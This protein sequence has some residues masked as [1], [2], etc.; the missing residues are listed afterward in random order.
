M[1]YLNNVDFSEI[2]KKNCSTNYTVIRVYVCK[3][4]ITSN[5]RQFYIHKAKKTWPD[6]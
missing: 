4:G 2:E 1:A 6:D 3:N 5:N